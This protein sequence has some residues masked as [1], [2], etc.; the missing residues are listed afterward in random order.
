MKRREFIAGLGGAAV[1]PLA[2]R[3][4][5]A[6]VPVVGVLIS[7]TS[8]NELSRA[9]IEAFREG[10]AETG[11]VEG[12][13]VVIEYRWAELRYDRLPGLADD[14]VRRQ[15]AVIV[16]MGTI[17]V[18][19]AAKAATQT[20]PIVFV[21]GADP[22]EY[23]LVA[24]LARPGGNATGFTQII[25]EVMAKRVELLHQ[26]VPAATSIAFLFNPANPSATEAVRNAGRILGL[27]VL[28]IGAAHQSDIEPAFAEMAQQHAG[29]AVVSADSLFSGNMDQV[30]MLAVRRG[31][32]VIFAG[33]G[34]VVAGGLISYGL[35]LSAISAQYREAG[36]YT[37]RILKG[38][39]PAD[40]PVQ[41]P[42]KFELVINL[43]TAKALGL[44]VPPSLL[45]AADEVIE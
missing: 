43:K 16:A 17:W 14:L 19:T 23:G 33:R 24:S 31:L 8:S 2:A 18:A 37:G 5:Q 11:F 12:R 6:A 42:T 28:M 22:V 27:Q 30:A 20:V 38:E 35:S 3:A 7:S 32:P 41:L 15:V 10:L 39:K 45:V 36:I 9:L 13:T 26:L 1:W 34:P 25:P 40:L 29:V 21:V 4:Q 44:T